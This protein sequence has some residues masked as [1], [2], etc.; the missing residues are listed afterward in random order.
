MAAQRVLITGA[1]VAGPTLAF[2]LDRAG[3]DVTVVERSPELRLGGQNV[4]IRGTGREVVRRMNLEAT[5]LA[6]GTTE[7]GTR[8]VDDAGRTIAEFPAGTDDSSGATAELEILRGELA[9]I[10][11]ESAGPTT[12]Y[13]YGDHVAGVTQDAAGVDIVFASGAAERFDLVFFADGIRSSSRELVFAGEADIRDL[14]LY[15]AYGTIPRIDTD[16]SWWRWMNADGARV[17]GLRPDNLGT[18]RF[19]LSWM[20]QSRGY[21]RADPDDVVAAI[22]ATFGDVGGEAPRILGA[23]GSGSELYVDYLSQVRAPRWSNGRVALVGDAAWC[24][25]PLSGMGTTL[26]VTGAYILAGEL[27]RAS[28]HRAAFAQYDAVMRPLV[29]RAQKL[30]PGTPKVAHPSTRVGVAVMRSILRL[31]GSK[32][33]RVLASKF[34][35]PDAEATAL[36]DYRELDA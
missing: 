16:D 3:F 6:N 2:W 22:R 5:L 25:T 32:P 21:E 10:L 23:V 9:R 27:A 31:A 20:S 29:D 24:A 28:D 33:A 12:T 17:V 19:S 35:S 18:T 14:G 26:S 7:Q 15:T 4:D 36:P 13:R 34:A 8:F 30:P 11:V 1:S